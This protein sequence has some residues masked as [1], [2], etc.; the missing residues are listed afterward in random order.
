MVDPISPVDELINSTSKILIKVLVN[1]VVPCS[2]KVISNNA[3]LGEGEDV[4]P[5][6]LLEVVF[7]DESLKVPEELE[8]F[9]VVDL[10][11]GVI[12]AGSIELR[13]QA[14]VAVSPAKTLDCL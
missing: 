4:E 2:F 7:T 8:P 12:G 14:G 11:H 6:E 9:L 3:R 1:K 5:K 10:A 13:V